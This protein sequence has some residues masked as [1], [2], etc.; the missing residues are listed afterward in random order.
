MI[1][2]LRR[3]FALLVVC[4]MS[5]CWPSI[6]RGQFVPG[7][8]TE[9]IPSQAYFEAFN[10]L[11][12][13]EYRDALRALNREARGSIRIGVTER[14]I[15]AICYHAAWGEVLYHA[16]QPALALE[17]FDQACSMFLQ[18]PKWMLQVNFTSDPRPDASLGRTAIPW[19]TST[20]Q[21]ILGDIP[22]TLPIQMGDDLAT[23]NQVAQQGGVLRQMQ[24][25]QINVMEIVRATSLAIRRRNELLGPL[26][27]H[28]PISREMVNKLS[29]GIAPPN[30]WS[31]AW[32]DLQ[33]GLAYAGQGNLDQANS[34]LK[35]AE[36]LAGRFD[37]PLTCVALL[38]QGRLAMEAGKFDLA[39][40]L[41]A[42]ASYSAFYYEDA[43][44]IDEAFRLASQ[45]RLA[46][47]N[48]E[49]N[50]ALDNAAAWA[51]RE[52]FD[53]IFARLCFARAEEWM[54]SE[55]WREAASTLQTGQARLGDARTGLLGNWSQFLEA[56][57][58]AELGKPTAINVL[59]EALANQMAMSNRMLQLQLADRWF[60]QQQLRASSANDVYGKLL[61][62]PH[63]VD[64]AFRPLETMAIMKAPLDGSFDRWLI[65]LLERRDKLA[66]LEVSDLAKRRRFFRSLPLGGRIAALRQTLESPSNTLSPAERTLQHDLLMRFPNYQ[67]L[68]K[69]GRQIQNQLREQWKPKMSNEDQQALSKLWKKWSENLAERERLLG[70][71]SLGRTTS[72]FGFPQIVSIAELQ[73]VLKPGQAV[74]IFHETAGDLLGFLVTDRAS[75]SWNCGPSGAIARSLSQFLRDLGSGD[76]NNPINEKQLESTDWMESGQELFHA[77]FDGSSIDPDSMDE[78][79]VVPDGLV[80]Y[81]PLNAIPIKLEDRTVPLTSLS[82][83]RV[84]PTMGLAFGH[85]EPWRR[86]QHSSIIGDELVPGDKDDTKA[87]L[88][89]PLQTAMPNLIELPD[90]T[91]VS[92]PVIASLL[93]AL[94]VLDEFDIDRNEPLAWSPIP[95]AR[96]GHD[97]ELAA[98][99]ALPLRGPQRMVF[100][101]AHTI[102]EN[103]GK[104]SRRRGSQAPPGNELFLASCGLMSTGAQTILLSRWIVGGESTMQLVREF[105]Q[106]LHRTSAA[107]AWQR[108]IEVAKVIQ[109]EPGL[110]PR[111]SLGN[112]DELPTAEHPFFWSGYLLVDTG[113][114]PLP[115]PAKSDKEQADKTE[116]P[117]EKPVPK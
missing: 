15:D 91:P 67:D 12:R 34:M 93:D 49:P 38:E 110:E 70:K 30:H 40:R 14:W 6:S 104:T 7:L 16:G 18:D 99:L 63:A 55:N 20:R 86:V 47:P 11:Y 106:E 60:D 26:A 88:L 97:G 112:V 115:P 64:W 36:R 57:V 113:E 28:D 3:S 105:V 10:D 101:G 37:H 92:T 85:A 33:L 2:S 35:R 44:V 17:Q 107:D 83:I 5:L 100:P 1:L 19:G 4:L 46:A 53:H 27:V 56:R 66:A 39:D 69:S 89:E 98:W 25:W 71:M 31:N 75:T 22:E 68:L 111:V 52:R 61:S 58:L 73:G 65:A 74:V 45:N 29:S 80:W 72:Q 59:N 116:A 114:P 78:L 90:P 41:F 9:T 77:L 50:P 109:L 13:G 24:M 8:L 103:G 102:A 43:G 54:N 108:C 82:R 87:E 62:D 21:F 81:V 51:R 96:E 42:E 79:V 117:P 23:Q 95:N 94:V 48:P 84:V 76:R 32:A